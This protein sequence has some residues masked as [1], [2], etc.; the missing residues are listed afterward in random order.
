[1]KTS[2][3][4]LLLLLLTLTGITACSSP[5]PVVSH[6]DWGGTGVELRNISYN[7][8]DLRLLG[9][10]IEYE[11]NIAT[12]EGAQLL[13]NLSL[14]EAKQEVV[15]QALRRYNCSVIFDPKFKY[16]VRDGRVLRVTMRGTPANFKNQ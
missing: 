12:P 2:F 6:S 15:W 13:E 3:T 9:N 1:M 16:L 10:P 14:P 8:Y 11:I 7:S 5:A 4:S